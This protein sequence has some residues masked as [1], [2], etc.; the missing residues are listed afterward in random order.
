MLF[1]SVQAI[2][3]IIWW[4]QAFLHWNCDFNHKN[5][6]KTSHFVQNASIGQSKVFLHQLGSLC[7][8]LFQIVEANKHTV[9]GKTSISAL[10]YWFGT[11]FFFSE[12]AILLKVLFFGKKECFCMNN[13]PSAQCSQIRIPIWMLT[14]IECSCLWL[15]NYIHTKT[16]R[17]IPYKLWSKIVWQTDRQTDK[18]YRPTY[19][20]K[21][22]F[23]T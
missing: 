4:K 16:F 12:Q 19:F 14:K 5:G 21:K 18:H 3:H 20:A 8:M 6:V 10:E 17:T 9:W 11:Q 22:N 7:K 2:I 23:T 15:V 1:L 13:V